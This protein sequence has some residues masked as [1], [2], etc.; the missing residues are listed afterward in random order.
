M[1]QKVPTNPVLA[2]FVGTFS[3]MR[4]RILRNYE[5]ETIISGFF[6]Q[7]CNFYFKFASI[8]N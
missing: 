6:K 4:I 1:I 8:I 5:F 3:D 7:L 2:G